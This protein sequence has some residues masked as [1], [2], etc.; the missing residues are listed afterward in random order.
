MQQ[1]KQIRN[2]LRYLWKKKNYEWFLS[3]QYFI[4]ICEFIDDSLLLVH[5]CWQ[6]LFSC[7]CT[8]AHLNDEINLFWLSDSMQ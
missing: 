8:G 3:P 1:K 2:R 5:F 7:W 6:F 4:L